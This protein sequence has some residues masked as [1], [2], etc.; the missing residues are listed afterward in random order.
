[1]KKTDLNQTRRVRRIL[2]LCPIVIALAAALAQA[3]TG[4]GQKN[5]WQ[6]T[7]AP[8][9]MMPW[10][11]GTTA[12][13]GYE[14][15]VNSDPGDVFS[16]LQFGVMGYFE[17]RNG[18]WGVG[19]DTIYMALGS[20]IDQPPTNVDVNQGA[21]TF[22]GMRELHENVDLVF[23]ARW[24]VLQGKIDFKGPQ[25]VVE[26]TKQWVDPVVGLK[27]KHSLGGRWHF[28]LEGDIGGFGAMSKFA[29][30]LFPV[31]GVDVHKRASLMMGY[32]V[33]SMNYDTGSG[34]QYFKYDVT[35]QAIVLGAT[36]HF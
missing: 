28:T 8:Y 21:F 35:T 2:G 18:P 25:I 12:V 15:D 5:G 1:M 34:D 26:N 7:L 20:T 6:Y 24:N 22:I 29:W 13:K 33:L 4:T 27:L 11:N 32:R 23:G 9:L 36:F 16:N 10:M 17:A 30:E 19:V 31:V 3:Q 14:V